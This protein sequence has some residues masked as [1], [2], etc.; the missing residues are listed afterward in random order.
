MLPFAFLQHKWGQSWAQHLDRLN[1]EIGFISGNVTASSSTPN[2][3]KPVS[4]HSSNKVFILRQTSAF[5]SRLPNASSI[6]GAPPT[7]H[8]LKTKKKTCNNIL[9]HTSIGR[10]SFPRGIAQ[11]SL[12]AI[13]DSLTI[14]LRIILSIKPLF[15]DKR[16]CGLSELVVSCVSRVAPHPNRAPWSQGSLQN[17]TCLENTNGVT[18]LYM[19]LSDLK[20][21]DT[22]CNKLTSN[23][24]WALGR[25]E[26]PWLLVGFAGERWAEELGS[27]RCPWMGRSHEQQSRRWKELTSDVCSNKKS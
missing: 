2:F 25:G 16:S 5:H 7:A 24:N 13:S 4:F 9:S 6:S 19:T 8:K 17:W 10:G 1:N 23:L 20:Y 12:A 22:G 21:T 11:G 3:N 27:P 26:A 14:I 15:V 18:K